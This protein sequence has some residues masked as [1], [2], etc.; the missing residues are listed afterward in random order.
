MPGFG[1]GRNKD[2]QG[3]GGQGGRAGS[4]RL[5]G[6]QVVVEQPTRTTNPFDDGGD[7]DM[8]DIDGITDP[9]LLDAADRPSLRRRNSFTGMGSL[10]D[11]AA[12]M[13]GNDVS[14][15]TLDAFPGG[16]GGPPASRPIQPLA[17]SARD[18]RR[19]ARAGDAS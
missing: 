2:K 13:P 7:G 9:N 1:L 12:V 16:G 18:G 5:L 4:S 14:D 15:L 11:D 17:P 8:V 6:Q 10:T 19:L 3:G